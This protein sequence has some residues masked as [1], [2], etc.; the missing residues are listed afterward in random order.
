MVQ[1]ALVLQGGGALGAYE[2]GVVKNLVHNIIKRNQKFEQIGNANNNNSNNY[3]RPLFDIVA[4]ASIGAVNAAIIVGNVIKLQK[5][6]PALKQSDIWTAAI[7]QLESFWR[8]ISDPFTIVPKWI[9]DSPSFD[10]LVKNWNVL[11]QLNNSLFDAWWHWVRHT[12][13]VWNHHYSQV[14]KQIP[15]N[16]AHF[17]KM[18]AAVTK[19]NQTFWKLDQDTGAAGRGGEEGQQEGEVAYYSSYYYVPVFT[20]EWPYIKWLG[21]E[22]N[23]KEEVPYIQGYFYLPENYGPIATVEGL[24]R[25]Y[26]VAAAM[27]FGVPKVLTPPIYQPDLKFFGSMFTRTDNTPLGRTIKRYWDYDKYPIRTSFED[28]QPRLFLI[29]VDALDATSPVAFDSY[30]KENGTCKTEYGDEEYKHVIEYPDGIKMEH[31]MASM[32]IHMKYK[33]PQMEAKSSEGGESQKREIRYMWDGAYLSNTPLRE[34]LYEHRNYW[35]N[36]KNIQVK[37]DDGTTE[38]IVPDMEVYI[39]NLYPSIENELPMDADTIQDREIDIKFHDRTKYDLRLA[40]IATDYIEFIEALQ[41]LALK[42]SERDEEFKRDYEVLLDKVTRS[43]T[44]LGMKPRTYR[45][46]VKGR[47]DITKA[48]YV[49]R[50]D[51]GNTIFG[52]ASEFTSKTVEQLKEAGYQDAETTM[53]VEYAKELISNLAEK[54][55]I[56]REKE[57]L[58]IESRLQRAMIYAKHQNLD[59]SMKELSHLVQDVRDVVTKAKPTKEITN[60]EESQLNKE[61]KGAQVEEKRRNEDDIILEFVK[62]ISKLEIQLFIN[63][64]TI[65]VNKDII[66]ER[67][68]QELKQRL[69]EIKASIDQF[70]TSTSSK[71]YEEQL[72]QDLREFMNELNNTTGVHTQP[73]VPYRG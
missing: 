16:R 19:Q 45:D 42:H 43:K 8:E 30:V 69:Q 57:G 41:S 59:A 2:L 66:S 64:L 28:G 15:A 25:Y 17:N 7:E 35:R 9:R 48:V 61:Q 51:D 36:L 14:S 47:F 54:G 20:E 53:E 24:R 26:S 70:S 56:R 68:G 5:E 3:D 11:S 29:S 34:V 12:R 27:M 22:D 10:M 49:E 40:Q 65:A 72:N 21:S 46:L 60:E 6:S 44:H 13:E 52:K 62:S 55:I 71:N 4:G 31:V 38:L 1:R 23:W 63:R 37:L 58:S 50:S 33:Y 67:K 18:A 39:I 73:A 32:S